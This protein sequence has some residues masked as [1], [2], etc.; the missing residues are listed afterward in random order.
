MSGNNEPSIPFFGER[1]RTNLAECHEDLQTLF[2]EVIKHFDC[3]VIEGHRPEE[4]QQ[5][6]FHSGKS[7]LQWPESKH[8]QVPSMAADVVPFPIDWNDTKRFYWFGGFVLGVA[9]QLRADG[10]MAHRIRWGGD[11]DMDTTWKD[12]TFHDLP[13]YELV[14]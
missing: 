12:Q 8:N 7:K 13:H 14:S 4:E 9:A 6:A 10:K 1:S 5:K 11:W 3:A 2:N